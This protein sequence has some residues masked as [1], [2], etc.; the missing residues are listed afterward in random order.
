MKSRKVTVLVWLPCELYIPPGYYEYKQTY[1]SLYLQMFP[2][3]S[4]EATTTNNNF[5]M[6]RLTTSNVGSTQT[7]QFIGP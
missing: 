2:L 1:N 6:T 7:S 4:L 5:K 3:F